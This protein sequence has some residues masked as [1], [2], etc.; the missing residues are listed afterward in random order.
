MGPSAPDLRSV[1]GEP[2]GRAVDVQEQLN[3]FGARFGEDQRR[4]IF[5]YAPQQRRMYWRYGVG[6]RREAKLTRVS[7]LRMPIT[8]KELLEFALIGLEQHRQ[9]LESEIAEV[10]ERIGNGARH[11]RPATANAGTQFQ[12]EVTDGVRK[13]RPMSAA[14]RRLIA[15]GQKRRWAAYHA[16]QSAA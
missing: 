11:G 3:S 9:R 1:S 2:P 13:R 4:C 15:A 8:N 5:G 7:V 10:N 12:V 14:A 6:T 16:A